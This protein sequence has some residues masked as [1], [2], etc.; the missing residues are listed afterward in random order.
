MLVHDPTST[1]FPRARARPHFLSDFCTQLTIR[2]KERERALA[3]PQRHDWTRRE[4]EASSAPAQK[5]LTDGRTTN[6]LKMMMFSSRRSQ[7]AAPPEVPS[8]VT[9]PLRMSKGTLANGSV[10]STSHLHYNGSRSSVV[11]EP[12]A[13]AAPPP[14]DVMKRSSSRRRSMMSKKNR[15]HSWHSTLQRGFHRARSRSSGRDKN[16]AHRAS[17]SILDGRNHFVEKLAHWLALCVLRMRLI[18]ICLPA[19]LRLL[20]FPARLLR[21]LERSSVV[22]RPCPLFVDSLSSCPLVT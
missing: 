18:R 10:R 7:A 21:P 8:T 16:G 9:A 2:E 5:A 14:D 17:S 13:S 20:E 11:V 1:F 4:D 15:P 22:S 19:V 6:G 12:V 3:P